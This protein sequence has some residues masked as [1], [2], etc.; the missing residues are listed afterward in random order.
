MPYGWALPFVLLPLQPAWFAGVVAFLGALVLL[1]RKE[2]LGFARPFLLFALLGIASQLLVPEGI[3]GVP[4]LPNAGQSP[5]TT[6]LIPPHGL[7]DLHGWN[8][9]DGPGPR[10]VRLADGFFRVTRVHPATGRPFTE[11][12]SD[13]TYPLKVGEIYTQSFYFRHDGDAIA[14]DFLF[15]TKRGQFGVPA[16]V[17]RL[18]G[19]L[20]RAHASYQAQPGDEAL[21]A[22]DIYNLR[23]NWTYMDIGYAQ[24]EVGPAPSPYTPGKAGPGRWERVGWW[25]GTALLGLLVMAGAGFVLRRSGGLW[26]AWGVLLGLLIHLGVGLAQAYP[27]MAQRIAGL[28]ENPNL[29]GAGAVMSVLLV[30]LLSRGWPGLLA[31]VAGSGVVALSDSRAAWLGLLGGVVLWVARSGFRWGHLLLILGGALALYFWLPSSLERLATVFNPD[32]FSNRSRLEI[33][34]VAWRAFLERPLTGIGIGGFQTYYL[35]HAP[36]NAIEPTATHVHN[37]FLSLL[38]EAGLLGLLGFLG[39]WGAVV[40]R[41]G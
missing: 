23:G 31:L 2:Q 1:F 28:S 37:L 25:L 35:E 32:Y 27:N 13:R 36:P 11:I 20:K 34:G 19:G 17:E 39:L 8:H 5:Q 29:Y 12:L 14:F 4:P 40:W 21:R 16:K 10:A 3:Q 6:N 24:L 26:A 30:G 38:A 9:P 18:P 33:W 15:T 22:I 7:Y 41:M